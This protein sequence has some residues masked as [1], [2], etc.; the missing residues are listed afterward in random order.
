[1]A[2]RA[3]IP[4]AGQRRITKPQAIISGY[5]RLSAVRN[6]SEPPI[7][8]TQSGQSIVDPYIFGKPFQVATIVTKEGSLLILNQ[9]SGNIF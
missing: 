7:W 8:D 5:Q 4:L 3:A 2:V 6:G 9:F 1:M